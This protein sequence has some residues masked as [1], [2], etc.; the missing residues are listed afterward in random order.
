MPPKLKHKRPKSAHSNSSLG[1]KLA[2]ASSPVK[3][4]YNK[5]YSS[6]KNL[7]QNNYASISPIFVTYMKQPLLNINKGYRIYFQIFRTSTH[8][9]IVQAWLR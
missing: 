6:S 5:E 1:M 2:L 3:V 9:I 8:N 7:A 4:R